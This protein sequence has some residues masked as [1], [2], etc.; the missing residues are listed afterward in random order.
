MRSHIM[1]CA[2]GITSVLPLSR[3]RGAA[4][5]VEMRQSFTQFHVSLMQRTSLTII[6]VMASVLIHIR[7][8][9]RFSSNR[10]RITFVI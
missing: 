7:L 1:N 3:L 9:I 5:I 6:L 10:V 8:I 2:F 4:N